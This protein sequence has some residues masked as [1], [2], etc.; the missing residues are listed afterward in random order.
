MRILTRL[1]TA[2]FL[3]LSSVSY[4]QTDRC[5]SDEL[6]DVLMED[7]A[8]AR[9]YFAFEAAIAELQS[10]T[11]LRSSLTHVIPVVVHIMHDGAAIGTG[12]NLS[13]SQVEGAIDALNADFQGTFGGSD[14]DVEFVLASRDPQ[15]NPSTGILRTNVAASIPSFSSTGMVTNNNLD[16]A[17]ELTVK[18]MS[19]W[20]GDDYLNIWVLHKMNG[21]TSPLGFA[22]L[23]P[24]SGLHDGVAIHHQ[25]FGVGAEY[26][27]LTNFDLN[28]TL[29]H[30][31]GHYL[32]LLHTF[33][34]TTECDAETNCESQGDR[35]CDTPPTTGSVGCSPWSCEET[36]VE[37]FMDYSNDA[38]MSSFTEGQR[39]RMR[40]AL[41]SHRPSLLTSEGS[42]PVTSI[43]AGISSVEGISATGCSTTIEPEVLIRN[44][45]TEP[46]T[47]AS[48]S[49]SLNGGVT[50]VIPWSGNLE[51]G[52]QEFLSLPP[53]SAGTGDHNLQV[54]T[55]L[56]GDQYGLNDTIAVEFNIE[57][58]S[59]L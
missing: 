39:T 16:P 7:S 47:D 21:G 37:N 43:D 33:N 25:V 17:A 50:N 20:P 56:N 52:E 10:N 46:L 11:G 48:V 22:Y 58:G 32:G 36:M 26:D 38:C 49:F 12:S 44:F 35:V 28:R 23:P 9:S 34:S 42:L 53:L 29:T 3:V 24:T 51:Y 18:G 6:Q 57:A 54:W 4:A 8:Y 19:H 40:N 2:L 15:G 5:Q 1:S 13:Q 41:E 45:G 59:V 30:E 27:L 14:I 55:A 31:V